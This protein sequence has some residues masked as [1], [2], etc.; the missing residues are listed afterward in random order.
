MA[1]LESFY[2]QHK[3]GQLGEAE[4]GYRE[5]LADNP[6]D[7][8]AHHLLAILLRQR[9]SLT[10][11]FN[12]A[13]RAVELTPDRVNYL[14]TLAA[15]EFHGRLFDR[16]RTH[17][18]AALVLD[19]NRTDAYSALGHIALAQGDIA[20]AEERFTYAMRGD[21]ERPEVL[22]GYGHVLMAKGQ[23]DD[24]VKYF[25]RAATV[26][27]KDPAPLAQLGR[28]YLAKK[29]PDFALKALER[30]LELDPDQPLV[31]VIM[32]QAHMSKNQVA[33]ARAALA[34]LLAGPPNAQL[35][36]QLAYGDIAR[37]TGD[38]PTALGHYRA[39]HALDPG[40][41]GPIDRET[42]LLLRV[43]D[44]DGAL[45]ALDAA[46]AQRPESLAL[47]RRKGQHLG[48]LG[49]HAEAA[50]LLAEVV[51]DTDSPAV[52]L[53][54]ATARALLGDWEGAGDAAAQIG[55]GLGQLSAQARLIAARTAL[56]RG[57]LAAGQAQL[58]RVEH[59]VLEAEQQRMAH[60]LGGLL[61]DSQGRH[62]RAL[63]LWLDAHRASPRN[64]P[65]PLPNVDATALEAA[66]EGAR[67]GPKPV[68]GRRPQALLL[69]TP[70]SGVE[71]V[72]ALLVDQPTL[73]L[74]QDR[75]AVDPRRDW[76]SEPDSASHVDLRD[77]SAIERLGR[78]Y[79]RPL[80]ASGFDGHGG[81]IDWIPSFDA[82][83]LPLLHA[84]FGEVKLIIVGRDPRDALLNWLAIG[85]SHRYGVESME[86]AATWLRSALDHLILAAKLGRLKMLAI[87]SERLLSDGPRQRTQLARFL[88]L[89]AIEPGEHFNGA[90]R[91][92]S[93]LPAR[94]PQGH[95]QGYQSG[96]ASVLRLL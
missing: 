62:E 1:T 71:L 44:S 12:H 78:R 74:R 41:F 35:L 58:S 43:G 17:F 72:A 26:A 89:D 80:D 52:Q 73:H 23:T 66:I 34:P 81:L 50:A 24:A 14:V 70:G 69:G 64:P 11:A 2:D 61:N 85:G 51:R 79:T 54:L 75:F 84:V 47:R 7:A 32:A 4:A 27:P 5:L 63:A 92:D 90:L 33:D 25:T 38:V 40:E 57:D 77:L 9:G 49:R 59:E 15:L 67:S 19:P 68:L 95:W 39:A 30:S 91:A 56:E 8:E 22:T 65:P 28:A 21:Q 16:A 20:R 53:D 29:M 96:L 42:E 87:D 6:L 76:V 45:A 88:E 37:A 94:L 82:R 60:A 10:E 13:R 48:A 93:G 31:R 55:D 86:S 46:L 18:E 36:G 3:Q 83:C